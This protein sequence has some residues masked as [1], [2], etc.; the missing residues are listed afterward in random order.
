NDFTIFQYKLDQNGQPDLNN[1][2]DPSISTGIVPTSFV[3]IFA[4]NAVSYAFSQSAVAIDLG[5]PPGE[6]ALQHGGY[7]EGGILRDVVEGEGSLF[8][9][10][11]RGSDSDP[12]FDFSPALAEQ[13][14]GAY[15]GR[16][17]LI[18]NTG[19]NVLIGGGGSDV[20]EGRGGADVLIG[21]SFNGDFSLDFASYES[22]P[23]AVTVRLKGVGSDTQTAIA[24]GGGASG[25]TLVGIG[26]L[27]GSRVSDTV[28]GNAPANVLAGG[29]RS[30]VL[31]R[32]GG[33][34][35]ADYSSDHFFRTGDTADQV[36]VRLGLNGASGTGAE[37]TI[38]NPFL[39]PRQVSTDTLISIENVIGTSGND[40][41]VGNEQDNI[42]NGRGGNDNLDGGFGDDTLI[43]GAG[44]DT[45]SF[46][47]H[48]TTFILSREQNTISLGLNGADGHA[49]R[50]GFNFLGQFQTESDVLRS[51]ENVTGSNHAETI[52]G[53]E[54]A[55]VLD[56]RGGNEILD[57]GL[58]N[59][60]II[61]G[62]GIDTVSYVS[63][64][65][66]TPLP[67][68]VNGIQLGQNGGDGFFVRAQVV[69][70]TTTTVETDILRGIENVT[71]SNASE[72]IVGNE[73]DNILDGRGGNNE[74]RGLQ[75]NDT[76]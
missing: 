42:L 33:I 67:G 37:F 59:D 65:G 58:G 52:N 32:K 17:G 70:G 38:S 27:I 46:L 34:D 71:G 72:E 49:T 10:I 31:D 69:S 53:N 61:G 13:F 18:N 36:V 73:L 1:P 29:F 16:F 6:E 14:I 21:G 4:D 3:T 55:N 7:A 44:I 74:F 48:D 19:D 57:G 62:P 56:G 26:G 75:G 8:N 35:T 11:I 40:T 28:T 20:L 66:L 54:Q 5:V 22:S 24:T 68:E 25:D 43:G 47:S 39:P 64:D 9:D 50:T 63:H 2:I 30:R 12:N 51:I 41:I 23:A 60:T 45:A 15:Q 76:L